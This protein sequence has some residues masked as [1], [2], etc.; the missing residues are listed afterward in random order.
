MKGRGRDEDIARLTA[1]AKA[2]S[3]QMDIHKTS[4]PETAALVAMIHEQLEALK[5]KGGRRRRSTRRR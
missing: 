1:E 5:K 3:A 2:L 4:T